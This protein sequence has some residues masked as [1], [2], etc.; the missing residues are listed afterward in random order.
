ML[1]VLQLKQKDGLIKE[2]IQKKKIK[3][4]KRKYFETNSISTWPYNSRF[5]TEFNETA[6]KSRK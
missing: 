4:N 5:Y 6:V 1:S 2:N 3:G